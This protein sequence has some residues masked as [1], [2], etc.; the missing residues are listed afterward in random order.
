MSDHEQ[1]LRKKAGR[2]LAD[3]IDKLGLSP[4]KVSKATGV[5]FRT[6]A[7][8]RTA[9]PHLDTLRTLS[10]YL[11]GLLRDQERENVTSRADKR[12]RSWLRQQAAE[13]NSAMK[14]LDG[15]DDSDSSTPADDDPHDKP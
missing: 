13:N 2:Q 3:I 14:S 5:Y 12:L 15:L 10:V 4:H 9:T 6:V 11:Q 1:R 7:T 8:L